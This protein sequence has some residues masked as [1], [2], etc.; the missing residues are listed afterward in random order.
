[1]SEFKVNYVKDISYFDSDYSSLNLKVVVQ[2]VVDC[3]DRTGDEKD[4]RFISNL[5]SDALNKQFSA[6]ERERIA[7]KD[8]ISQCGELSKSVGDAL[9]ENKV[10]PRSVAVASITPD[11]RSLRSIELINKVN[12]VKNMS[13]EDYTK[14]LDEAQKT[15]QARLASMTPKGQAKD[16]E[17]AKMTAEAEEARR[18]ALLKNAKSGAAVGALAGAAAIKTEPTKKFCPSCGAPKGNGRFCR[19][20]GQ[21][22]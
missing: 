8:L 20:C 2:A 19:I 7:Y 12:S 3:Q 1:M 18:Q 4:V 5:I 14:R 11:E 6:F 10:Q 17:L 9:L 15:A 21:P 13:T 16:E 22:L